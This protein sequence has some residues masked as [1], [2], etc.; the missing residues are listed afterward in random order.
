[1]G[2][3]KN[4]EARGWFCCDNCRHTFLVL[5]SENEFTC[6]NCGREYAFEDDNVIVTKE[7]EESKEKE[8]ETTPKEIEEELEEENE[9]DNLLDLSLF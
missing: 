4:E 2:F 1:M 5:K 9:D 6:K 3:L 7:P 8:P